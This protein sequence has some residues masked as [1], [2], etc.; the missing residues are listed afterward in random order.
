MWSQRLS[1][2]VLIRRGPPVHTTIT[3]SPT[4]PSFTR[5]SPT[6]A[7]ITHRPEPPTL[8]LNNSRTPAST[9]ISQWPP[10]SAEIHLY[11][12]Q[13]HGE[14]TYWSSPVAAG[15]VPG[16]EEPEVRRMVQTSQARCDQ[17]TAPLTL[18]RSGVA[19]WLVTGKVKKRKDG[20]VSCKTVK[21]NL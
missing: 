1:V 15:P 21:H 3:R 9:W 2:L 17:D 4:P 10:S 12:L 18:G 8:V 14:C 11:Q 5:R 7:S 13:I 6:S 16:L 20:L 19:C